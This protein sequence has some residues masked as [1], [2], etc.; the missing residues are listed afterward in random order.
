MSI[1]FTDNAHVFRLSIRWTNII[2]EIQSTLHVLFVTYGLQCTPSS[3]HLSLDKWVTQGILKQNICN[4]RF[5]L[6]TFHGCRKPQTNNMADL[7]LLLVIVLVI[8][9]L[10]A[11]FWWPKVSYTYDFYVLFSLSWYL[12]NVLMYPLPM[13]I[14]QYLS[15]QYH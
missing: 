1:A 5:I 13:I 8:V 3:L 10:I 2:R 12:N 14:N 9:I 4:V 15:Q 7:V 6:F 11:T